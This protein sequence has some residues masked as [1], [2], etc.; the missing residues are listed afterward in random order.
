MLC[1]DCKKPRKNFKIMDLKPVDLKAMKLRMLKRVFFPPEVSAGKDSIERLSCLDSGSRVL[2]MIS[3][4]AAA[5]GS[6]LPRPAA[7]DS[8]ASP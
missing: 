4:S 1:R 6:V 2:L 5:T 7:P 8:R 3:G